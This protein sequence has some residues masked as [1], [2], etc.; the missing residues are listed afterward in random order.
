MSVHEL[1]MTS[2]KENWD[3]LYENYSI[4]V[5]LNDDNY[6]IH[7]ISGEIVFDYQIFYQQKYGGISNYFTCLALELTKLGAQIKIISP[8][9]KNKNIEILPKELVFGKKLFYPHMLNNYIEKFNLILSK[10]YT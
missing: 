3:P 8:I 5:K 1:D 9:H 4:T 2:L 7:A 6:I 10:K